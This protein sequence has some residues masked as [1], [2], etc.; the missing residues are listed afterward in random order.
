MQSEII[1]LIRY[2]LKVNYG[3][4]NPNVFSPEYFN[5]RFRIFREITLKSLISQ[6]DKDFRCV[7]YHSSE[8]PLDYKQ[9]FL[10]LEKEFP[11]LKSVWQDDAK[12]FYPYATKPI[13]MS[14]RIDN[15]DAIPMDFVERFRP[16]CNQNFKDMVICVPK[17]VICKRASDQVYEVRKEYYGSN[18]IGMAYISDNS[19]NVF[20]LGNH[21]EVNNKLPL[22]SLPGVGGMMLLNGDN[23]MNHDL[24]KKEDSFNHILNG[25]PKYSFM[26]EKQEVLQKELRE[27]LK[28]QKYPDMDLSILREE[29]TW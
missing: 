17:I 10:D 16:F 23:V 11:F 7:L 28:L 18:S 19:K 9:K 12:I 27:F 4:D 21:T 29:K 6:T 22:I 2:S 15:D 14:I 8:M 1:V 20:E 25:F 13:V 24:H 5:Y 26:L 3:R